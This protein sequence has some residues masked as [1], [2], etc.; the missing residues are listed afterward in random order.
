MKLKVTLLIIFLVVS[1]LFAYIFLFA[2]K[3]KPLTFVGA[4]DNWSI[5]YEVNEKNGC[6]VSSGYIKYVGSGSIPEVLEYSI[7]RSTGTVPLEKNS[8]FTLPYSGCTDISKNS[9]IEAIIKWDHQSERIP[10]TIQ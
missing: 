7:Y 5:H 4:S 2:Y 9:D 8:V 6:R 3:Q 1:V 10:L